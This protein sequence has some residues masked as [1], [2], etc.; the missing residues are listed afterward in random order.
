MSN[1]QVRHEN[2]LYICR[3]CIGLAGIA[4]VLPIDRFLGRLRPEWELLQEWCSKYPFWKNVNFISL[5]DRR[6]FVSPPD[7]V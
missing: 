5:E 3:V 1:R 4:L 2:E 6:E 7:E